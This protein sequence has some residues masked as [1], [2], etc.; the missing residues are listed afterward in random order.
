MQT[1]QICE[2]K[3]NISKHAVVTCTC[4]ENC[5]RSCVKQYIKSKPDEEIHCMFCKTVWAYEF[6]S[7]NL[8]KSYM[9][10]EYRNQRRELLFQ[11][12]IGLLPETQPY[13]EKELEL[14]ENQ[15]ILIDMEKKLLDYE[16]ELRKMRQ[17]CYEL[18]ENKSYIEKKTYIRKCPSNECN[19]FLSTQLKCNL[20]GIWVCSDCREIKGQ[21]KDVEHTCNPE[22]VASVKMLSSDTKPCPNC[23]CMIHKIDGCH[24]MFCI[25]CHTAFHWVTLKIDNGIVHNPHYFQW[26][27]QRNENNFVERNPDE[28]RCGRE[29]NENFIRELM[30]KLKQIYNSNSCYNKIDKEGFFE[31]MCDIIFKNIKQY[32]PNKNINYEKIKSHMIQ[33]L[34]SEAVRNP[35]FSEL[36]YNF[37]CSVSYHFD[38]TYIFL[39]RNEKLTNNFVESLLIDKKSYLDEI[40]F[41]KLY[42]LEKMLEYTSHIQNYEIPNWRLDETHI[43]NK[44]R[45]FRIKY[46]RNKIT[47]KELKEKIIKYDKII[48][49]NRDVF[50]ILQMYCNCMI[51]LFYR[52]NDNIDDYNDILDE[53][54]EL[55]TY[56]NNSM[57]NSFKLHNSTMNHII[58]DNFNYKIITK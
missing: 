24:Q 12:Q 29:L 49:R 46:M 40:G 45:E 3:Y 27:R 8:E 14:E 7:N 25:E 22:I 53:M 39:L 48:Q 55:R 28:I 2:E 52:L 37:Q 33:K 34:N 43:I 6:I 56:T 16:K 31:K 13:V 42:N 35:R 17:K 38:N 18:K 44:H 19:G 10:T 41:N 51:D 57:K 47:E 36:R 5:C 30:K 1:C 54:N 58:D 20:C 11:K 21:Q 4:Q 9:K 15:K 26:L 32:F 23:S 50:N